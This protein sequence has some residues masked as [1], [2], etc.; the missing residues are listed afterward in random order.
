VKHSKPLTKHDPPSDINVE[1]ELF[2]EKILDT[3]NPS[4]ISN[5]L[6]NNIKRREKV[7]EV[8]LYFILDDKAC[9]GRLRQICRILHY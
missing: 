4:D 3:A 8:Y 5:L 9:L 2:K 1:N 7:I 6:L